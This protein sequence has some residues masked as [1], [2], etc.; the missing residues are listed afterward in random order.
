MKKSLLQLPLF[1][2]L[3]FVLIC[4]LSYTSLGKQTDISEEDTDTTEDGMSIALV[5]EDAGTEFNGTALD[6]GDAFVQSIDQNSNH[7]WFVVSRG[8]AENGLEQNTYDMMIVI[9][10]DFTEK[11]LSIQ[12][13]SPEQVVLNYKIN[14]SDSGAIRAEAE[15]TASSVLNDFNR[16]IIDVYFASVIGNLQDAQDNVSDLVEGYS[17]LTYTY[18]DKVQAPL[19]NYTDQ[20]DMIKENTGVSKDAFSSFEETMAGYEERLIEQ[21]SSFDDYQNSLDETNEV[22]QSNHSQ[23]AEFHQQLNDFNNALDHSDV[24]QQLKILQDTNKFINNQLRLEDDHQEENMD[25]IAVHTFGLQRML[26]TAYETLQKEDESFDLEEIEAEITESLARFVEEAFDEKDNVTE[27]L[28]AQQDLFQGKLEDQ[29]AELPSLDPFILDHSD[30]SPEVTREIQNV[31]RIT[32]KYHDEFNEVYPINDDQLLPEHIDSLKEDLNRNGV[33]L[34]DTVMLPES[35][36]K[37]R[38]FKLYDIPEGFAI[39]QL[40]IHLPDDES[41]DIYDYQPNDSVTLPTY[42]KGEFTIELSL[43]LKDEYVEEPIDIYDIKQWKWELYQLDKEESNV[44]QP[45]NEGDDTTD[46]N[47]TED[48]D[49]NSSQD[50]QTSG[51]ESGNTDDTSND[52]TSNSSDE[53]DQTVTTNT[54]VENKTTESTD[55][56]DKDTNQDLNE[57][58]TE[59]QQDS[60]DAKENSGNSDDGNN[61]QEDDT[62]NNDNETEQNNGEEETGNNDESSDEKEEETK[63]KTVEINHHYIRHTVNSPIIDDATNDLIQ[64]VENT[65]VPYQKLLSSYESYFGLSLSCEEISEEDEENGENKNCVAVDPDSSLK[66]MAT[67]DSL[68]TLFNKNVGELLVDYIA[69]Q[70]TKDVLDAVESP[71]MKYDSQLQNYLEYVDKTRNKAQKLAKTI[72]KTRDQASLLNDNLQSTLDDIQS[73]REQS[74]ELVEQQAGIQTNNDEEQTMVV[75]LGEGF[76]S[77]YTESQTLQDQASNNLNEAE[78]VYQTFDRIDEQANEIQQSGTN[79][80]QQAET[81]ATNMTDETLTNQEFVNNFTDVLANSRIGER[82]NEQLYDFLSNPV[83]TSNEGVI[84]GESSTFTSYFI[85]LIAFLVALFTG[86]GI[87]TVSQKRVEENQFVAERS[88]IGRNT[89]ITGIIALI[90]ALEGVVLGLSSAYFLD[91]EGGTLLLWTALLTIIMLTIVL[92]ASYLLRQLRMVGMFILLIVMSMYLFLTN[93]LSSS[94]S[95]LGEWRNYS[96]LDYVERLLNRVVQ[97]SSDYGFIVFSLIAIAILAGLGNLLVVNR[98]NPKKTE[99]DENVA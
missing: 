69:N 22:V 40:T 16:R 90:G 71:L 30:L 3:S 83:Q 72:V 78:T 20:F 33:T 58:G 46:S 27:L 9:P 97:G 66:D 63:I 85:V 60:S 74:M 34:I 82:Q 15:R 29:I 1:L 26:D 8:I 51:G 77:L 18:N 28:E 80:I 59:N 98:S 44:T 48:G 11:A 43:R 2:I 52:G 47:P 49:S 68:Y 81:L 7:E 50:D 91:I 94:L 41:I 87:S 12:S 65:I 57:D 21:F 32:Q 88:I 54:F 75:S 13:E 76:Q 35:D 92:T 62:H 24:N 79:L 17:E 96:P 64:T 31:M 42:Q 25:S 61:Q 5:N 10:K 73:W 6:F 89:L 38:E 37:L 45:P 70:V 67:E 19:S 39:N 84:A 53:T 56:N 23:S 14:T 99:D 95:G 55:S 86:Y 4:G 93:A 36:K